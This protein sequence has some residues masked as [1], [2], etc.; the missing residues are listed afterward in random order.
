M[1]LRSDLW[2]L[3]SK[4]RRIGCLDEFKVRQQDAQ[5]AHRDQVEHL[6]LAHEK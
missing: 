2:S 1:H 4:M 3:A 5:D 6:D